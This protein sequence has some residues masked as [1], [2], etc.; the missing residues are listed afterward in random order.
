MSSFVCPICGNPHRVSARFCPL[1]GKL[2]TTPVE[3][4]PIEP[5][6]TGKL[7][8]N[9]I[10]HDRYLILCKI[11]QGGMAAVY[12]VV[13]T[14]N[15]GALWAVKEMSDVAI[16]NTKEREYAIYAFQQEAN[17]LRQLNH[18]NLPKVVDSFSEGGKHYLVMEFVPGQTL[19][20]MSSMRNTPFSEAEVLPWALQLCHVLNYLHNQ[21]PKIIFRDLKPANIMLTPAGV[22]KLIDFGIARFFKPGK[23]KDT[24]ALGTPGFSPPEA[25]SG[26]TDER[27]DIYSLCVTLHCL[28][29]R[30]DPSRSAYNLPA[31]RTLIPAVSVDMEQILLRGLQNQREFRWG[32]VTQM[33]SELSTL[34]RKKMF[35]SVPSPRIDFVSPS[36]N[37]IAAPSTCL[38]AGSPT[39]GGESYKAIRTEISPL[40]PTEMKPMDVKGV[41]VGYTSRPTTRLVQAAA[42]MDKRRL[43]VLI[44]AIIAAIVIATWILAPLLSKTQIY[45][46]QVP[47]I[48]VFG[49]LGYTAFP[50]RG[51][52]FL[53]HT[54]LTLSLVVTVWARLGYQGYE[55]RALFGAV[56]V[57]GAFIEAWV[58][59]LPLIKRGRGD[60]GWVREVIWLAIMEVLATVLFFGIVTGWKSGL[61]P[62]QWLL[63]VVFGVIGWFM[64]DIL[65]QYMLFRQVGFEYQRQ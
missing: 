62:I 10:L 15:Q 51:I 24:M 25:M 29:T 57:S 11:G 27:S 59:L 2:I 40:S 18:P 60:D 34:A 30:R 16:R 47:V 14:E 54:L 46:N 42:Q 8:Q 4:V 48:A 56:L 35:A 49:A 22:I 37:S 7:P 6:V 33:H 13:D 1:T 32:K 19:L 20:H 50:K 53:S 44:V 28:L 65:N 63:S 61:E 9:Y 43:A 39:P 45:W 52:A 17:L 41:P 12:K 23:A 64:G 3:A 55:W 21:D 5:G 36:L 26:Q 58:S 31:I 38:A